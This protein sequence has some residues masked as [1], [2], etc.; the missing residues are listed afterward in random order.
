[1]I[2]EL[3]AL[4]VMPSERRRLLVS[5]LNRLA[6]RVRTASTCREAAEA[7]KTEAG[8]RVVL[9]DVAL[10]DGTWKDVLRRAAQG[11]S[12]A[13]V[14]L[15]PRLADEHLWTEVLEDGAFDVLVEPYQDSEVARIL[16]AAGLPQL[17]RMAAVG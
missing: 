4:V 1:M 13:A 6:A 11:R 12:R 14:V 10:P 5:C 3:T 7:L 8:V 17:P 9:T 15:C 16:D 2:H